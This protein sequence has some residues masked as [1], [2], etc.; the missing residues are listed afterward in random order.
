MIRIH[1][2][3]GGDEHPLTLGVM[4]F[5]GPDTTAVALAPATA[6]DSM[7][8]GLSSMR[9]RTESGSAGASPSTLVFSVSCG[10]D[11]CC[12]SVRIDMRVRKTNVPQLR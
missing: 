2:Y 7:A 6:M 5:R 3:C 9:T 10:S 1:L 11:G 4:F 8:G 12:S